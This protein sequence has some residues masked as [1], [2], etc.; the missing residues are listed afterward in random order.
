MVLTLLTKN[1]IYHIRSK[2][3]GQVI[4]LAI[5]TSS[6]YIVGRPLA[7]YRRI[8]AVVRPDEVIIDLLEA[9]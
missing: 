9:P 7:A 5:P 2:N 3:N 8:R 6:S 1:G 4:I